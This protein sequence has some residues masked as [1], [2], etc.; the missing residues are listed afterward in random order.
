MDI[1]LFVGSLMLNSFGLTFEEKFQ[2]GK[3]Y[4]GEAVRKVLT[5]K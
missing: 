1:F 2:V 4:K 3:A 5:L